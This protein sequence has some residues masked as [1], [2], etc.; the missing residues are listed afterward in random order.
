MP[1]G[2]RPLVGHEQQQIFLRQTSAHCL[3]FVGQQA[4]G[5]R[6]VARWYASY[7]NCLQVQGGGPCW[8]CDSCQKMLAEQHVDYREITPQTETKSGR[9]SR[10][11]SYRIDQFVPREQSQEEALLPWLEHRPYRRHRVAVIDA[12]EVLNSS[13]ANALLKCLEEP[14][15]WAKI[16]LLAEDAE[17][18]L[19]TILSRAVRLNFQPVYLKQDEASPLYK[20]GQP[21][22]Y[23]AESQEVLEDRDLVNNYVAALQG[24]L[25]QCFQASDALEKRFLATGAV[26]IRE[27]RLAFSAL[28]ARHYAAAVELLEQS[29]VQLANYANAP[30]VFQV[31]SLKLRRALS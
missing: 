8:S 24:D 2:L 29:E 21:G 31:L 1:L 25:E 12:A 13:S 26:I 27:L 22:L 10:K 23:T 7:L 5:K 4:I 17:A 18:V 11:P 16:I 6:L 20:L 14:Q 19:A 28:P 3:L 15:S 9:L 30:L